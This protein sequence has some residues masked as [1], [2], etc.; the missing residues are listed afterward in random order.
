MIKRAIL[1]VFFLSTHAF[2][3]PDSPPTLTQA[4]L[5]NGLKIL[6]KIDRRAPVFISQ[7][8]Y[9]VGASD[10][11][12]PN[13]GISHVLEHLMFKG[14]RAFKVGEFSKII[15]RNGGTDNAFTSKDF[16]AYY[17]MMHRSKLELAIKM[18]ADRMQNLTFSQT[19]FDKER[20][21][22]L[23]ER[24]LRVEDQPN[25]RVSETLKLISFDEDGAYHAPVIGF[26]ADLEQLKLATIRAWYQQ[27]YAPNN[28]TLVVVG[29]VNPAEVIRYA[30]QYFGDYPANS[31][32]K[33]TP[34][35]P[36]IARFGQSRV[37]K[38]KAELPYYLMGFNVPSLRTDPAQAYP[39]EMLAYVL[40]SGLSKTLIRQQKIAAAISTGYRLYDKFD[41][42]LTLGFV[43]AKGVKTARIVQE[44]KHQVQQLIENP[45][46]IEDELARIKTQL[47]ASF[48][49]E[50]DDISTQSYY[51]GMLSTNGFSADTAADYVK[52]MNAIDAKSVVKVAQKYLNFSAVNTVELVPLAEDVR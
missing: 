31:A 29:D 24:R 11:I 26:K 49:F 40:D 20:Q 16:T 28:A 22:V 13:T 5:K 33:S 19:E 47:E 52:K 3:A 21:V 41:S 12:R 38:L 9:S 6:V 30:A 37:L 36:S 7:L 1:L 44:I 39:L 18:E 46:L 43:P 42:Q 51:L 25:A 35:R 17:Q 23:E 48:V 45:K 4:T 14:T 8:W 15:A 27:F 34:K 32:V 50:Q 10:E 2:S